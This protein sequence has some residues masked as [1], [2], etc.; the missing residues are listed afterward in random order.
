MV[1][2]LTAPD[3]T[4]LK[5]QDA[6]ITMVTAYDYSFA[7]ILDEAGVEGLLVGDSLGMV[8]QGRKNT[9]GVTMDHMVY[10]SHCVARGAERAHVICDLPFMSY[11]S[12]KEDAIRA[13]GLALKK[14][15][16]EAV[17]LEGGE[18]VADIIHA[19]S[20]LGIP[21]MGHVGLMPQRVQKMGGYKIQGKGKENARQVLKDAKAVAE[22]GAYALVLESIPLELAAK[23]TKE[24]DIPTIGIG[25]GPHCDGQVL[26]IYDLLGMFPDLS[27]KFVKNYANLHAVIRESV[28]K[29]IQEVRTGAFPTEAQSFSDPS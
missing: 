15:R 3:I 18:E 14:G 27:P 1:K 29:F 25:S 26:V 21:V 24:V 16:A 23:I 8:I 2:K 11:Q 17:K 7:R 6:K 9:L 19:V 10:H 4:A 12:S 28:E 22:A 20:S 13:S 5:D